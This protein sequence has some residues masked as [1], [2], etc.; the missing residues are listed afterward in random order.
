MEARKRRY[1][2]DFDLLL[3]SCNG[4][5]EELVI[6]DNC[7]LGKIILFIRKTP[8][9]WSNTAARQTLVYLELSTYQMSVNILEYIVSKLKAFKKLLIKSSNKICDFDMSS[10][11][12]ESDIKVLFGHLKTYCCS[13]LESCA[14]YLGTLNE[15]LKLTI[16]G[17]EGNDIALQDARN[18]LH[19]DISD[20]SS[21]SAEYYE[22]DYIN[23]VSHDDDYRSDISFYNFSSDYDL[24]SDL[25]ADF[26]N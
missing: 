9:D 13:N 26:Y 24:D 21:D 2:I 5:L 4:N 15:D 18:N 8:N 12:T 1:N 14:L 10:F 23:E 22:D 3:E 19:Y 6:K 7:A 17:E 25:D 20:D 11:N 16:G